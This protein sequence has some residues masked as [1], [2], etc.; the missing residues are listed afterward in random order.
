[1]PLGKT[2]PRR[3]LTHRNPPTRQVEVANT[4]SGA[5]ADWLSLV[6]YPALRS[7]P[8]EDLG[9]EFRGLALSLP[10]VLEVSGIHWHDLTNA[11]LIIVS[12]D[13]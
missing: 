9:A 5:E 10:A 8:W 11:L 12:L 13:D 3:N 2:R 7:G 1:M 6:S 4:Y